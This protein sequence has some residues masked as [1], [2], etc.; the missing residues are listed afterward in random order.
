MWYIRVGAILG[1]ITAVV[2]FFGCWVYSVAA[3]GIFI[4]VA[5]G[6]IPSL[7]IAGITW[8]IITVFWMPLVGVGILIAKAAY[9]I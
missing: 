5:L 4:G 2:T 8:G 6:W 7:I 3:Y 1:G 9:H